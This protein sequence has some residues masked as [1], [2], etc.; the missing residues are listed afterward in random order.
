MDLSKYSDA[1]L[2]AMLSQKQAQQ[3]AD[4]SSYSDAEL[5][6]MANIPLTMKEERAE[7]ERKHPNTPKWMVDMVERTVKNN[8]NIPLR[9]NI[10]L[11]AKGITEGANDAL[12]VPERILNG[13][14]LGAWDLAGDKLANYAGR[15]DLSPK[16]RAENLV[17]KY[18]GYGTVTNALAE[19]TGSLPIGKKFYDAAKTGINAIPKYGSTLSKGVIPVS[20]AGGL[21]GGIHG[22][23]TNGL[24]GAAFGALTGVGVPLVLKGV[25]TGI[26]YAGK[27]AK[28]LLGLY[29]GTSTDS[30]Q[31][32]YNAGKRGSQEFLNNMR[33]KEKIENVLDDVNQGVK[34]LKKQAQSQYNAVKP[35]V[36][37][38]KTTLDPTPIKQAFNEVKDSLLEGG[39]KF[40]TGGTTDR[41]LRKVGR[42]VKEFLLDKTNHNA[43]G[44]DAFKQRMGDVLQD[45]PYEASNARRV[46]GGVYNATKDSIGK[47]APKYYEMT[48]KYSDAMD[49]I[50]DL[51]KAFS[52]KNAKSTNV[53]TALRKI[54]SVMRN[55]VNTNYGNR[56]GLLN[57]LYNAEQIKDKIAGQ[58]M[59][60]VL[61]KGIQKLSATGLGGIGLYLHSPTALGLAAA[62]SPRLVGE[63]TYKAGQ[64]AAKAKPISKIISELQKR[65]V[66]PY[67]STMKGEK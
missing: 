31:Q 62:S 63:A 16:T 25:G 23:F 30:V 44:F 9:D 19:I 26:K 21:E 40:E 53:D 32:A 15:P 18:D 3:K 17:K 58:F 42:A 27:G 33:G 51:Q 55:N 48:S 39:Q 7:F 11:I 61:P 65:G 66:I 13:A 34:Q 41:T 38:D 49:D 20:V 60:D 29:T 46:V 2:Q 57:K 24:E 6:R 56:L 59:K 12:D 50:A 28:N 14:S 4:L 8:G 10:N 64:L 67:V 54:Q 5:K 1:E 22:G 45:T 43:V 37:G 52:L 36:F 35:E 47:Q